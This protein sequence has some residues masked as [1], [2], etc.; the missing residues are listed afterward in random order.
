MTKMLIT[1]DLF[2][3]SDRLKTVNPNY[4][5]Y[6]NRKT[7]RYEVYE[8][9]VLNEKLAFVVPYDELDART[10]AFARFTA[11]QNA[12]KIFAEIEKHNEKTDKE[13]ARRIAEQVSE[14]AEV[15]L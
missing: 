7:Q 14:K 10:L 8:T 2:D 15:M 1:N 4:K 12:D 11:V 13:N 5:L 9:C 3:I 6:F